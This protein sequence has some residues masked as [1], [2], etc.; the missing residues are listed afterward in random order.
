M[1]LTVLERM[2]Y[3]IKMAYGA[4]QDYFQN[5]FLQKIYRMLQGSSEICP[6]WSLSSSIQFE[7]LDKQFPMAVFPTTCN[8]YSTQW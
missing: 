7:I 6:I 5:K 4:L 2:K 8:L 3:F 1:K